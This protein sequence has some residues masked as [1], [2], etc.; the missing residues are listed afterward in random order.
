MAVQINTK[1]YE[2]EDK[3]AGISKQMGVQVED[4]KKANAEL[5]KAEVITKRR[6]KNVTCWVLFIFVLCLI[7]GGSIYFFMAEDS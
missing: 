6:N 4:V 3:L 1:I 5:R 7:L 2:Q